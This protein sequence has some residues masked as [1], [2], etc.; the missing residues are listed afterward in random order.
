MADTRYTEEK[1]R[2]AV[3]ALATSA[4][5]IQERLLT[6]AL[7]MHMLGPDDF[8]DENQRVTLSALDDML[9]WREADAAEGTLEATTSR[10]S[11]AQAVAAAEAIFELYVGLALRR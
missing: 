2:V 8:E 11:D 1:L 6:A 3:D 9:N 7:A 4:A 10:M 5:P